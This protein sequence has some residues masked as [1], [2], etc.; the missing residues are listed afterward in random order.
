MP[1]M[2]TSGGLNVPGIIINPFGY[3][4]RPTDR[5]IGPWW[6]RR[7]VFEFFL[8]RQAPLTFRHPTWQYLQPDRHGLTDFGSVPFPCNLI[9]PRY[10]F[11]PAY[12]LHDRCCDDIDTDGN[13]LKRHGLY[14]SAVYDGPYRFVEMTPEQAAEVLECVMIADGA[15]AWQAAAARR[16]VVQFGPRWERSF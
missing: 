10:R 8:D 9:V 16:A 2:E 6:D 5:F 15:W 12:I 1:P 13:G 11:K 4:L 14:V 3:D 7:P